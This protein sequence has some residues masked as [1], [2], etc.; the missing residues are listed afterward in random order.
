MPR[1]LHERPLCCKSF[2]FLFYW[3]FAVLIFIEAALAVNRWSTV[4]TVGWRFTRR[5]SLCSV[6]SSWVLALLLLLPFVTGHLG[7]DIGWNGN[8]GTCTILEGTCRRVIFLLSTVIPY[9]VIF[10][11]YVQ[12]VQKLR[13]SRKRLH[14]AS[15]ASDLALKTFSHDEVAHE[16]PAHLC[17][18]PRSRAMS[19]SV[20]P[21]SRAM[22]L[23]VAR[24]SLTPDCPVVRAQRRRV[25]REQ[26]MTVMVGI[27]LLDYL[28]FTFP[29]LVILEM[30][31][32]ADRIEYA[33]IPAYILNWMTAIIN[34]VIYVLCNPTYRA[35]ALT[36][37]VK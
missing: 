34:P 20:A 25:Q 11:C 17:V 27:I 16:A 18:A 36:K 2:A 6:V 24:S 8:V 12:I 22:S 35:A 28:V 19:L 7:G 9:I 5:A 33:H 14:K 3:N 37:L 31:T 1:Y 29:G 21:R 23:S 30:D 13:C 15:Q 26:G 4:C 32:Q 10:V